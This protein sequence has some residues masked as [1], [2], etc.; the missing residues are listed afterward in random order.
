MDLRISKDDGVPLATISRNTL[1][2]GV[3]SKLREFRMFCG[4]KKKNSQPTHEAEGGKTPRERDQ[5][6]EE[7]LEI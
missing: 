6:R 1:G 4:S 7:F 2:G 3:S 5:L